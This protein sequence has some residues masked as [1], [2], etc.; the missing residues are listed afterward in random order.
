MSAGIGLGVNAAIAGNA[1]AGG[2]FAAGF[3][4]TA[5][6]STTGFVAG[7]ATGAAVGITNEPITGTGYGMIDGQSFGKAFVN[8]GLNQ[9]W[10]Q[11]L[12]GA[13][14]GGVFGDIDASSKGR[15]FWT[16]NAKQFK[17]SEALYA[18]LEGGSE[19]YYNT[20]EYSVFNPSGKD[21]Y[22]KP[23]DGAFGISNKIKNGHGIKIDVDGIATSKHSDQVFKIPGKYGFSPNAVVK[24]GGDVRLN[25]GTLDKAALNYQQWRSPSYHYGWSTPN[26]LDDSWKILFELA[27]KSDE[28]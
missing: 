27:K 8:G 14:V 9:A 24:H 4:G 2:G 22:H 26:Q 15:N 23:E 11:G 17:G 18:S 7:A 12:S 20:D 21:V 5:T 25:F 6:V 10:K 1:A 19:L 16:G 13:A 3:T 28:S